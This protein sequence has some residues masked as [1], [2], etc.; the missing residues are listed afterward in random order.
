MMSVMMLQKF[1]A[2]IKKIRLSE[3]IFNEMH[4]KS[5]KK[6]LNDIITTSSDVIIFKCFSS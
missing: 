1:E 5:K 3:N 6:K 4:V 2:L